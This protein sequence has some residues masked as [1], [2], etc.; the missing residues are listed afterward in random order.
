MLKELE[1]KLQNE[2]P[3][4]TAMGIRAASYEGS[5]LAMEM[6]LEINRNHQS[7]AFAGSLSALCT[8]TGWGT[9]FLELQKRGLTGNIV[10]RRGSIRYLRPV[11]SQ[12]IVARATGLD[13]EE[14]DYFFDLLHHKG[15][16]KIAV[17]VQIVDSEGPLVSFHGS[18]VVQE[19]TKVTR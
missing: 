14:V 17:A 4:C 10:I 16:S 8:V 12:Q 1:Q 18:Y 15:R 3:I 19:Y 11:A 2:M 13:P 6:P 7:T 5:R 9:V